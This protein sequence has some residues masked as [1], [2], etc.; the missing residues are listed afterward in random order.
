VDRV[1]ALFPD[2]R[3]FAWNQLNGTLE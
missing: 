3:A 1:V 2:G